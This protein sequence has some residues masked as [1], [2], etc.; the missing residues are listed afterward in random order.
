MENGVLMT[1]CSR[2][3]AVRTQPL[4]SALFHHDLVGFLL[5][6]LS[7]S[8]FFFFFFPIFQ[9][10]IYDLGLAIS[11]K[12]KEMIIGVTPMNSVGKKMSKLGQG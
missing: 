11:S 10:N 9:I 2:A 3:L 12:G 6:F 4:M 1:R 7:T 5:V 8:F